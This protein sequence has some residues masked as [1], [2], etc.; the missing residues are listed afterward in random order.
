MQTAM[1]PMT[2]PAL[3]TTIGFLVLDF[4]VAWLGD[5][6]AGR[7]GFDASLLIPA[8]VLICIAAGFAARNRG[9]YGVTAG[10][11]ITSFEALSWIVTGHLTPDMAPVGLRFFVGW[12]LVA[13]GAIGGGIAGALGDW[14]ARWRNR[15]AASAGPAV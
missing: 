10:S 7:F 8:T 6:A 13:V 5:L 4:V 15:A 14:I 12:A 11:L 1:K 3:R 9:A 2:I